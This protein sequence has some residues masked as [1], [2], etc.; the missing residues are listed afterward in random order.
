MELGFDPI[1]FLRLRRIERIGVAIGIL[2]VIFAAYWYFFFLDHQETLKKL[3]TTIQEQE[4][5]ITT[6]KKMLANLPKLRE[7]LA[8]L[9][10][11]KQ[12][13]LQELPT[14]AEIPSLLTNISFAGHAQGL[15]F[16]LFA[17]QAENNLEFYA[18]VPVD[19]KVQGG[20]HDTVL[21]IN[22]VARLSR[23]V[24]ISDVTM[25][26]DP[27]SGVI[28]TSARG[29]TYRYIEPVKQEAAAAKGNA[30]TK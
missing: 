4:L 6:K 7:E 19:L 30:K 9:E 29:T 12:I 1:I 2:M 24:N 15:E 23:L 10:I 11:Q 22:Q 16:I 13:A 5:K 14:T 28:L 26:P 27:K 20:F 25:T 8:Q 18:E 21:F 17:P 3:E